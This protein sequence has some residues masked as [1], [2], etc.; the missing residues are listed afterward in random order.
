MLL[1]LSPCSSQQAPPAGTAFFRVNTTA[2]AQV[3]L[4]LGFEIQ[5][6]SI[7]SGNHGLPDENTSVPWDLTPSERV[8]FARELLAGFRFCRLALGLYFRGLTP[9]NASIVERWPGQ[10]GGLAEMAALS[11]IE[12]FA[13]EYWSPAPFWKSNGAYIDGGLRGTDPAFMSAFGAAVAGDALYLKARGIE[14]VWWALQNEPA[15]GPTGCIYSCAGINASTY[16][17]AFKATASAVRKALPD[18]IIHASSWSGQHWSPAISADPAALALV[19]VWTFH[20]VGA[21]SNDQI[22]NAAYFLANTSGRPV[23]NNEFEYLDSH[24]DPVRTINTAQSIM[25][26]LV[27]EDAPVWYW[28]HALKPL[29]NSEADGYALGFWQ[30]P[31]SPVANSSLAPGHFDLNAD[32]LNAIAGFTKYMPWNAV[33]VPVAEDAVRYD[34]RVLAYRFDPARA[35]WRLAAGVPHPPPLEQPA[36]ATLRDGAAARAAATDLAVVLTNR[37]AVNSFRAVVA[38]GGL[39]A[40]APPPRFAGFSYGPTASDV[41][42]GELTPTRN[43]T[44]G[45]Y[46][47]QSVLPPLSIQFWVQQ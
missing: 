42:L 8:R 33:R 46:F 31:L 17:V 11:G 16:H 2:S 34:Q 28:L 12:G 30:P 13:V 10:S 24:T 22:D 21:D 3:I 40:G 25:N 15:V 19:D 32:N 36:R 5:S 26:W 29:T 9:D 23:A 14:P 1:L 45:E 47:F 7:G 20:R 37:W 41:P 44:T 39:P 38:L 18:A 27:F 43:A 6:D 4:G 35:R